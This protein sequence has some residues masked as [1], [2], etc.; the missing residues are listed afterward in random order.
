[1]LYS[2][3][4]CYVSG[5]SSRIAQWARSINPDFIDF[6]RLGFLGFRR[7]DENIRTTLRDF[8]FCHGNRTWRRLATG[9]KHRSVVPV[10]LCCLE[11]D[12]P[13]PT[14]SFPWAVLCVADSL[15]LIPV[16]HSKGK[17]HETMK[18]RQVHH[19]ST[20]N[21]FH[22]ALFVD[23]YPRPSIDVC[24]IETAPHS[25]QILPNPHY[26]FNYE[27]VSC[28]KVANTF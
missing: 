19:T 28:R 7:F 22:A 1:M 12:P 8:F 24:T 4:L 6:G 5:S 9:R 15:S 17:R 21:D 13:R 27:S 16:G 3:F 14:I 18:R 26:L 20:S 11:E 25:T 23:E 2:K 10:Q